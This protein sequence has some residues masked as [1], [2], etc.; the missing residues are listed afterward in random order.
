MPAVNS[1]DASHDP[2]RLII[3]FVSAAVNELLANCCNQKVNKVPHICSPLLVVTNTEGKKQLVV[4][5]RYLN[6][7]LLKEK[8]KYIG[9]VDGSTDVPAREF[10]VFI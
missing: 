10:H 3:I 5:L 9:Y 4:N 8:F 6:Q 1:L 2:S 7:H